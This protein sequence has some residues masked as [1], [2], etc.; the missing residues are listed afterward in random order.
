MSLPKALGDGPGG[1]QLTHGRAVDPDEWGDG[2]LGGPADPSAE[3]CPAPPD[4]RRHGDGLWD[5]M[6]EEGERPICC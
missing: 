2:P 5:P 3:R 4:A 1:E 6:G